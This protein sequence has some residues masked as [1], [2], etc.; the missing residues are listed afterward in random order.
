MS[1]QKSRKSK[2]QKDSKGFNIILQF[3]RESNEYEHVKTAP[4]SKTEGAV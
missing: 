2:N 3:N 4:A 1:T